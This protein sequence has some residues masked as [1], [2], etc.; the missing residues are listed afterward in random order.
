[1]LEGVT[2][3]EFKPVSDEGYHS[4]SR[5][6]RSSR[7]VK[8]RIMFYAKY[9]QHMQ[10]PVIAITAQGQFVHFVQVQPCPIRGVG[11]PIRADK[12]HKPHG[13]GARQYLFTTDFEPDEHALTTLKG[14]K[15]SMDDLVLGEGNAD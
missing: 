8:K 11:T 10:R 4:E 6:T 5:F 14:G 7:N 3:L 1:M 12:G 2:W 15:L 13:D 9:G